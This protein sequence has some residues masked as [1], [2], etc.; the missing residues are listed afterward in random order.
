MA[1][2]HLRRVWSG[3]RQLVTR[4]GQN[5]HA[6]ARRPLPKLTDPEPP[7]I[8]ANFVPH[9]RG[10][11]YRDVGSTGALTLISL[12]WIHTMF[13]TAMERGGVTPGDGSS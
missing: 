13:E 6:C 7:S 3:Q 9:V 5:A 10:N 4:Y 11:V 2:H 1:L 12:A 8:D